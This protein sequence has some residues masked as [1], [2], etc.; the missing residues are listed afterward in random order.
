MQ[1]R[2]TVADTGLETQTAG[3]IK[4]IQKY[5]GDE[6]FLLASGDGVSTVNP[7]DVIAHHNKV[8]GVVT[9]TGAILDQRFGVLD[10]D[11]DSRV[12]SFRE[13][14]DED[15]SFIN[16]GFMVVEPRGLWLHWRGRP[17]RFDRGLQWCDAGEASPRKANSP[18]SRT[19]VSGVSWTHSVT[20]NS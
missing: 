20:S 15:Q 8:G 12:H 18:C 19:R 7:N 4:R 14:H 2:V 16:G 1:W 6:P 17:G 13:K 5:V 9:V 10:I 11:G 3:R